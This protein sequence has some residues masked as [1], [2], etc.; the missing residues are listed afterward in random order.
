MNTETITIDLKGV[1]HELV[2]NMGTMRRI[3]I[4]SK[5]D[6]F[7]MVIDFTDPAEVYKYVYYIVFAGLL[8]AGVQVKEKDIHDGIEGWNFEQLM[9]VINGFNAYF[10]VKPKEGEEVSPQ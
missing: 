4:L 9:T 8:Q 7:K 3:G 5:G 10:V 2:V 1:E 6:P